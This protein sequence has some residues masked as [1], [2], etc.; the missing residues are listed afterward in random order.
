[1]TLEQKIAQL[2][3]GHK[4]TIAVAESCTGGLLAGSLTDISGSSK[5]FKLGVTAYSNAAKIRF[6]QIPE[7]TLA[8]HG[9]VSQPTA[10]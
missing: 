3:I 8:E 1:M 7:A 5:F 10:A 4:K 9:A 2:L 6:L